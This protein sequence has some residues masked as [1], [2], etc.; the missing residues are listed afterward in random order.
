MTSSFGDLVD[1]MTSVM[2]GAAI[3]WGSVNTPN[4]DFTLTPIP[5][6][7]W[8]KCY[9]QG[10]GIKVVKEQSFFYFVTMQQFYFRYYL[11]IISKIL[12]HSTEVE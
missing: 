4:Q 1:N 11:D 8:Y 7:Q 9:I 6:S 2:R 3:S 5:K 12:D 10:R